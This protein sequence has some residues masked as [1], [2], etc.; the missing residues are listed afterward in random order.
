MQQQHIQQQQPPPQLPPPNTQQQQRLK[1][2]LKQS[3]ITV[4]TVPM[5]NTSTTP[6]QPASTSQNISVLTTS[7]ATASCNNTIDGKVDVKTENTDTD[8]PEMPRW[9]RKIPGCKYYICVIVSI[10]ILCILSYFYFIIDMMTKRCANLKMFS[11]CSIICS[12]N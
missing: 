11:F 10:E 3:S 5:Q 4:S 1:P 9:R 6:Q 7:D 8:A 2:I 12:L